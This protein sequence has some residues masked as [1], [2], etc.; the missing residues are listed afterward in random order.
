LNT[1][2]A[3]CRSLVAIALL[4]TPAALAAQ[5][6]PVST[7]VREAAADGG[8]NLLAA[9]Q[10]MPTAKYGYKPTSAQRS[11]AQV[12]IHIADDNRITCAAI[13][14][15]MPDSAAKVAPT[16]PKG[17]LV[18]ALQKSL[19]ACDSALARLQDST[20]GAAVTYYGQSASRAAAV[21]GLVMDWSDHYAQLAIY[22]RLNGI[23]PPTVHSGGK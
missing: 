14:G 2:S 17:Q 1:N 5:A 22:L 8:K 7:A 9:V 16:D 10:A 6:N 18:A 20:L 19:A 13:A 4:G 15:T 21:I 23:L 3:L 12:V 11:F